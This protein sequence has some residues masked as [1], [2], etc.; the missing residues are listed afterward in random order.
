MTSTYE[1]L[2]YAVFCLGT[3]K[4][5]SED[6]P[7]EVLSRLAEISMI[8]LESDCAPVLTDRGQA[9]YDKI[10]GRERKYIREFGI[11]RSPQDITPPVF[12]MSDPKPTTV[13]DKLPN[14]RLV[15]GPNQSDDNPT[16]RKRPS[17]DRV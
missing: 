1:E 13:G 14:Q 9:A 4:L 7:Q 12:D 5:P 3:R 10:M 8:R 2:S 15:R 17:Q 6:I 16:F 11:E